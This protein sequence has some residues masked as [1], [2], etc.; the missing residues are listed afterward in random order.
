MIN[1]IKKN[2]KSDSG[3]SGT[4]EF[5]FLILVLWTVLVSVIDFGLYFNDRN[6][7]TNAPKMAQG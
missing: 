4:I 2:L 6:I 1:R 7:F 3:L 5:I